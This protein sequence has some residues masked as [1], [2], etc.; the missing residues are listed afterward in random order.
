MGIWDT[1]KRLFAAPRKRE[2]K[3]WYASENVPVEKP[4]GAWALWGSFVGFWM[5]VR[6]RFFRICAGLLA[7][8]DLG[9]AVVLYSNVWYMN[10]ILWAVTIPQFLILIHYLRLTRS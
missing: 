10:L 8:V 3:S 5:R 4:S 7:L 2:I 1:L 6:T 9:L